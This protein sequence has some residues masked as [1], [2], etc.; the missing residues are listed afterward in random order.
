[1]YPNLLSCMS[2]LHVVCRFTLANR[3]GQPAA[4]TSPDNTCMLQRFTRQYIFI[5]APVQQCLATALL[6]FLLPA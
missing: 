4:C 2:L 3:S 1:M 5:M 6:S